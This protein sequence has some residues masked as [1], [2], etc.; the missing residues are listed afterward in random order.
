MLVQRNGKNKK[1]KTVWQ[2]GLFMLTLPSQQ[3][4]AVQI[5]F[6]VQCRE[7]KI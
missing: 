3:E 6:T 1:K 5:S 2:D 7:F 4:S